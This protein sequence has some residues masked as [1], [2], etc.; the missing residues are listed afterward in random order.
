M[1]KLIIGVCGVFVLGILIFFTLNAQSKGIHGV[2]P[3]VAALTGVSTI[4]NIP[5]GRQELTPH[6]TEQ[7]RA[8]NVQE[9]W[10]RLKSTQERI[11]AYVQ[12][13]EAKDCTAKIKKYNKRVLNKPSS[14]YFQLKLQHWVKKCRILTKK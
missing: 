10:W 12:R 6:E 11:D 9:K 1:E 14:E 3:S 8:G 7:R 4:N 13:R 2:P 5:I